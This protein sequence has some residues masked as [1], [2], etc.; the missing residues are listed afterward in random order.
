MGVIDAIF[1]G[2][3]RV[4]ECYAP[5]TLV[6]PPVT[7]VTL[8]NRVGNSRNSRGL[9]SS[10]QLKEAGNLIS[11]VFWSTKYWIIAVLVYENVWKNKIQAYWTG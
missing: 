11:P 3:P 5:I 9:L 8:E 7:P 10:Q 6:I 1:R 2:L 4:T